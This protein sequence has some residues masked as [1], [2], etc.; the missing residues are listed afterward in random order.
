MAKA[1]EGRDARRGSRSP[2]GHALRIVEALKLV[3]QAAPWWT[4]ASGLLAVLQGLVPLAAVYL[5]KLI[6]DAVTRGVTAADPSAAW[7]EVAILIGVAAGVAV[8]GAAF[9]ALGSLTSE[10][11]SLTVSDHVTDVIHAKSMAV[12]LR[13]YEDASYYDVLHRA[14]QEAPS[15]PS[16]IV[17]DL[18]TTAQSGVSLVGMIGLLLTLHW[19]IGLI[20]IGAAIPGALV[21]I[22]YS[23]RLFGWQRQRTDT[24]RRAWYYHWLLVSGDHAKEVRLFDIGPIA[25]VW[26]HDVRTVLRGERLG[27]AGRRAAADA[28]TGVIAAAAVFGTFAFIAW[29]TVQ[30]L[31]SLGSLVMYYQAFQTSLSSLQSVLGGLAGLYEDGLFLVYY[32]EFMEMEPQIKAPAQP[33]PV[34]RPLHDGVRFE[35]VRFSYPGSERTAIEKLDLEL[36]AGEV[37]ALVGGNG[38]GK[39][40]LVKLLCRLYDP[41]EGRVTFDGVDAREMDPTE[42]RRGMSVIFQDFTRYQLSALQNIWVGD[43][44]LREGGEGLAAA[45]LSAAARCS[46]SDNGKLSRFGKGGHRRADDGRVPRGVWGAGS[47][48]PPAAGGGGA[49]PGAGTPVGV[50][51]A[52]APDARPRSDAAPGAAAP[53]GGVPATIRRA[54]REAGAD[55]LITGLPHGYDTMLGRWFTGGEELSIG[56]WQKVALARAFLR[57]ADVLVLDEPTSALDPLAEREVFDRLR[58]VADGRIVLVVSHRFSTVYGADRIHIMDGG[59]IIESGSHEELVGVDGVYAAMWRAQGAPSRDM[60][61]R[62]T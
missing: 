62:G 41:E 49:K 52:V 3:W 58:E 19:S 55:E 1:P 34:P 16:K 57:S 12:D 4:L 43:V 39:T 23:H 45:G 60:G 47:A 6:V 22:R 46:G 26:Y 40:T 61:R 50:E 21:R 8:A 20:V 18:L 29:R 15:R 7:R 27:I 14:Q 35:G 5:M 2:V 44:A 17:Q 38:S 9:R 25:R 10:A 24:E 37:T 13:F 33:R 53:Q 36:R 56:E 42:L 48:S 28:A 31:I 30:G 54:A 32:Q 51:T 59:R 11:L